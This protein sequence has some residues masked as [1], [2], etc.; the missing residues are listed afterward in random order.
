MA[1]AQAVRLTTM[2]VLIDALPARG[3]AQSWALFDTAGACVRSGRD[4]PEAWPAAERFE[5]VLAASQVRIASVVLPPIAPSR[6]AS[7]AGFA[8]DDQLAGPQDA[9]HLAV[10]P[11]QPDGRVRVVIADRSLVA[12]LRDRHAL[13]ARLARLTRIIAEP[14]L[15]VPSRG[16][17]WCATAGRQEGFVRRSDGTA[18]PV[19]ATSAAN[20]L[21]PELVLALAHSRR[22][23]KPPSEVRAEFE[24][25]DGDL[26]HWQQA[27]GVPFVQGATWRW[28][29]APDAAFAAAVDLLQ[30]EFA[31]TGLPV[32]GAR[33]RLFVPA[34]LM[35]AAALA[36]H[37]V[38][39][40]GEWSALKLDQWRQ[41]RE[42]SALAASAGLTPEI[43]S[44]PAAAQMAI[45]RRYAEL[46]HAH[47]LPA[48]DDAL[49]LLARSAP[50]LAALPPGS[51]KSATYADGHWT[52]DLTHADATV[53][54]DLDAQLKW[55][56]VPALIAPS[57]ATTRIRLGAL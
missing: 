33:R 4:P 51:V 20:S 30:G 50:A 24:A 49:P 53:V 5:A 44:T 12:A 57:A 13:P 31:L 54:S 6:V 18:F 26:A 15:A 39:T 56:G 23:G 47:G 10:S 46:R 43:A 42:W 52:L 16:W 22:D 3:R 8:I 38:L 19:S 48:P 35:V 36:L 28:A 37:V 1:A 11:Q 2:R 29:S 40:L 21:P 45:A 7:A 25:A 14:D 41:A 34:M 9:Q 27:T 55:A 17:R 32:A